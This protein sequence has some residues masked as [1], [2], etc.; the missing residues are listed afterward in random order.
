MRPP[1]TRNVD[2]FTYED[3]SLARNS[4]ALTISRGFARRPVGQW[5]RRRSSASGSS[6]KMLSSSG[7]ST[8]PGQSAFTRTPWRANWTPSSRD[9]ESTAPFEAE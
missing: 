8:G 1:S 2:A 4:A 5:I 6:P 9:I 7:V 3:S